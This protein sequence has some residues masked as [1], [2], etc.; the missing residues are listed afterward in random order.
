MSGFGWSAGD[1]VLAGKLIAKITKALKE[2]GGARDDYQ[3]SIQFLSGLETTLKN[4]VAAG[5]VLPQ[6]A[7]AQETIQQT[8]KI[9]NALAPL[10]RDCRRF[11]SSLG[12]GTSRSGASQTA[13]RLRWSFRQARAVANLEERISVPLATVNANIGMQI[14]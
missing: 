11:E 10:L 4:L 3:E 5:S 14:L 7:A 13:S 2:T 8:E 6:T 9:V 12:A 1:V